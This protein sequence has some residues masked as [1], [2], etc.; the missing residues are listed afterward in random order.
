MCL[1]Q[2]QTAIRRFLFNIP[3][4][5]Y[6]SLNMKSSVCVYSDR[7]IKRNIHINGISLQIVLINLYRQYIKALITIVRSTTRPLTRYKTSTVIPLK[8]HDLSIFGIVWQSK[9]KIF[10]GPS[11]NE[12]WSSRQRRRQK[13]EHVRVVEEERE[14]ERERPRDEELPGTN[15][16]AISWVWQ[17]ILPIHPYY[18]AEIL[19]MRYYDK[20]RTI[21]PYWMSDPPS[22]MPPRGGTCLTTPGLWLQNLH[23]TH[24][25]IH[26]RMWLTNF[27][28][29][30][31]KTAVYW[32]HNIAWITQTLLL[33]CAATN[34]RWWRLL[35]VSLRC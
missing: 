16:F 31:R 20:T 7:K 18:N 5:L 28:V 8:I 3:H 23:L 27:D 11:G 9:N 34:S 35:T 19:I 22:A 33:H 4:F 6:S 30:A 32:F 24:L 10:I 21:R 13:M 12:L 14:R 1:A 2:T 26:T 29:S 17:R 25:P 15:A